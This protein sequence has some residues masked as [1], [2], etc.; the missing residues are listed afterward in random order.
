MTTTLTKKTV[1]TTWTPKQIQERATEMMAM[2][3]MTAYGILCK[4]GETASKEFDT[5]L[6][7]FKAEHYK[8]MGVKTPLDLVK[9]VAEFEAN[10]FGSKIEI[11]GDEKEAHLSYNACGMWEA[12]KKLGQMTKEQEQKMEGQF[13]HCVTEFAKEFGFTATLKMEGDEC[14]VITYKK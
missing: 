1:E 2:Q 13:E 4:H 6:R 9:A 7:R 3:W 8:K 5:Q 12:M 11:W 10:V 14:C